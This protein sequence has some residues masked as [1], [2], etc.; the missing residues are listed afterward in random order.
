MLSAASQALLRSKE[1]LLQG[2]WL[3]VNPADG[4]IFT[5]IDNPHIYGFHQYFDIFQQSVAAV[6]LKGL[7]EQHTFAPTYQSPADFDGAVLYMPKSKAQAQMLLANIASCLKPGATILMVGEN[8]SGIKS[9]PKLLDDYS[10]QINKV[11]SARHCAVYGGQIDKPTENFD[12]QKWQSILTLN[13]A[14]VSYQICSLPGVFSHGELDAGTR[15]LLESIDKVGSGNLLDFACGTGIIGCFLGLKN[16]QSTVVMTDVS[17]LA[18]YCATKSAELNGLEVQVIPSN[19]LAEITGRFDGI[20]TN[21]P[22]HTGIQTDYSVT[23]TFINQLKPR[24]KP[25]GSLTLVANK[26]LRY[27][28]LLEQKFSSVYAL[29]QTTKFS[30]YYC[31]RCK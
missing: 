30:V 29:A 27:S 17:A 16:P 12:L 21:P 2:K 1:L 6:K 4:Q 26:F 11:D 20:Y 22:F 5:Q 8:K 3:L 31:Q 28:Q 25:A 9:A 19:G 24:L 13:V 15:L 7:Q 14:G 10:T 23:E 18:I